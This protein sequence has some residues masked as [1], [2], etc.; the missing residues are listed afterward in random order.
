MEH[1]IPPKNPPNDSSLLEDLIKQVVTKVPEQIPHLDALLTTTVNK[2][3]HWRGNEGRGRRRANQFLFAVEN[4][5]LEA[6][7]LPGDTDFRQLGS[8]ITVRRK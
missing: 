2:A 1:F 4:R 8:E 6:Q 3:S 7:L 5:A